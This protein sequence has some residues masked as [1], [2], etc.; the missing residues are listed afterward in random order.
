MWIGV[1]KGLAGLKFS[2][3]PKEKGNWK[4]KTIV[5]IKIKIAVII[6]LL[7]KNGWKGVL[8]ILGFI[9][10]G[11]LDPVSCREAKCKTTKNAS[12]N[13]IKKWSIKN[14]LNVAIPI[15]KPPHNHSTIDTPT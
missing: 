1:F 7:E 6:S 3:S 5:D 4:D 12:K 8:S 11:L 15:E 14:R 9:P 2:G 13:G 10:V